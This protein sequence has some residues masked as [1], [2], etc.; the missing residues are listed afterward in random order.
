MSNVSGRFVWHD[1]MT[2]D[3]EGAKKF[4]SEVAGWGTQEWEGGG[5]P[6]TMWTNNGVPFGGMMALNDE[7]RKNN[8]P[9]HWLPSVGVDNVDDT[10]ARATQL[11]GTTVAPPMDIPGAGRYAILQDPQGA[12]IAIFSPEGEM[13][14]SDGPPGKG[15]F[16]WHELTTSDHVAAFDFYSKLFGWEKNTEFDMGQMGMYLIYGQRGVQYGGMMTRTPD[17]PPPNWL[18][19]IKVADAKESGETIKRL[20]GTVMMEPMEVPDGDWIVV[21]RDPQGAVTAV[22]APKTQ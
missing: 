21:A 11:G 5:G 4:Y 12:T 18:C 6:Y 17:M 2:T 19:Y 10:V 8:V 16:S 15:D 9:P 3:T 1:L 22:H 7:M 20:G 13:Q 14:S